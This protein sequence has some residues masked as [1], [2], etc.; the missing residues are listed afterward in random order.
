MGRDESVSVYSFVMTIIA[1]S[2]RCARFHINVRA[3]MY[4]VISST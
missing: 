4:H 3:S 1:G 2:C